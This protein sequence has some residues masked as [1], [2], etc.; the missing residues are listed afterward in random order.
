MNPHTAKVGTIW[1]TWDAPLVV[2]VV[3][4][5]RGMVVRKVRRGLVAEVEPYGAADTGGGHV[6][7]RSSNGW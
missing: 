2:A 3:A 5:V 7:D 1:L 4:T 6:G